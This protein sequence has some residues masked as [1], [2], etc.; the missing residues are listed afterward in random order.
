MNTNKVIRMATGPLAAPLIRTASSYPEQPIESPGEAAAEAFARLFEKIESAETG[1][2]IRDKILEIWG[3]RFVGEIA[4]MQEQL[5]LERIEKKAMEEA[6][7]SAEA[8]RT[9]P[10]EIHMS[11]QRNKSRVKAIADWALG[12]GKYP[13]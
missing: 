13:F 12:V 8:G 1:E 4:H 2:M 7:S 11:N 10:V 5:E 6:N 3:E 9:E